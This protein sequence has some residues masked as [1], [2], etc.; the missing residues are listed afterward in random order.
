MLYKLTIGALLVLLLSGC[1]AGKETEPQA[2]ARP[3]AIEAHLRFLASDE[4]EG[5]DTGSRG[6]QIA[7]N[8]IASQFQVLGLKPAGDNGSYFQQVPL[9]SARLQQESVKLSFRRGDNAWSLSYPQQFFSGASVS[10]TDIALS[11][12]LVF[13]SYGLVSEEFG[14][15]DYAGLDVSGKIVV[16]LAGLPASLPSEERA[17]LGSIKGKL[18]AE[19]GAVG[20]ITIH[21]PVQEKTRPYANSL[22]YLN[23]PRLAWLD[24][25]GEPGAADNKLKAGAYLH[26]EAAARLFEQEQQSLTDIFLMLDADQ[27][28]RGFALASEASLSASSSHQQI[29]SP[30]VIAVLE[31]SDPTLKNEYV[32]ITAHSDHIGFSNDLRADDK[33][34]NGAMDN[35]AGMAILLETARMFSELSVKP[36]RSILFVVVTAEEK[37][38]LG[39][40]YFATHPTRPLASLVANV[41]LDMP[42]LLYPFADLIAFGADHST[43][44]EVVAA[45]AAKE[46]IALS[47]DPMPEQAIF[48]RSDHFTLVKQGVPAVFLMTGFTSKDPEQDGAK[49]WGSFF[50]KHY[51]KSSDD[52][53][54]LSREYGPVRYDAGAVFADIN[55][56]IA[57]DIANNAQRPLWKADSF[58]NKVFGKEYN[59][60]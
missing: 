31:G 28:P 14:L 26:P 6:H 48:T 21:T 39:A 2:G 45:A 18:A 55:F 37:G 17:Y 33:I 46:G 3:G 42:V 5:R 34:N 7:A 10:Q 43:L 4:L 54:S 56:N 44:G 36:Q 27:H 51:H 38:L 22:L 25:N 23:T 8:Y 20:V 9:R 57:L 19:R 53:A 40:D 50:A 47:A 52:I 11:A 16:Q 1:Y 32:V 35:A 29:S 24:A 58:F 15:D 60:Q 59:R 41:N 13:V 30:N 49:I 12:P